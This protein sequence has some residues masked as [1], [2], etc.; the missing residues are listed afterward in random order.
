MKA[1][2]FISLFS[3]KTKSKIKPTSDEILAIVSDIIKPVSYIKYDDKIR[4]IDKCFDDIKGS[5]HPTADL[6]RAFA[7]NMISAYTNIE[8]DNEGFDILNENSLLEI[9]L[10]TFRTEY[11]TCERLLQLCSLDREDGG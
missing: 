6:Q 2:I 9:V 11:E 10:L 5:V 1:N 7:I 8:L 4:I 3:A